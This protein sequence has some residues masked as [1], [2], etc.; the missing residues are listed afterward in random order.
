MDEHIKAVEKYLTDA[1]EMLDNPSEAMVS[2]SASTGHA[3]EVA[4]MLQMEKHYQT[5]VADLGLVDD[6]Y[7]DKPWE[8]FVSMDTDDDCE[9][10]YEGER[11]CYYGADLKILK[12]FK[13]QD[14]AIL[15]IKE[16]KVKPGG[17]ASIWTELWL[18]DVM[19]SLYTDD[20]C[21]CSGNQTY[22]IRVRK[23]VC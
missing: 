10:E 22:E 18:G 11:Y 9:L 6:L 8:L 15:H 19:D 17:K 7:T 2:L 13:T 1:Y 14:E 20:T 16:I 23:V 5:T 21:A 3:I 4:K 12:R